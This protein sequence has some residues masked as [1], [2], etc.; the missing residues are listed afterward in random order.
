MLLT[1]NCIF[2]G[3]FKLKDQTFE[4]IVSILEHT[5]KSLSNVPNPVVKRLLTLKVVE[6]LFSPK[7][8]ED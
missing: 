1:V 4:L 8:F 3:N 6:T 2:I 7:D 5:R